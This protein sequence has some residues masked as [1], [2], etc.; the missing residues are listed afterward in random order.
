MSL[1]DVPQQ[2][3]LKGQS[4]NA[5]SSVHTSLSRIFNRRPQPQQQQQQLQRSQSQSQNQNQQQPESPM[6]ISPVS[7]QSQNEPWRKDSTTSSSSMSS[8]SSPTAIPGARF[9]HECGNCYPTA[10][11]KFCPECGEKRVFKA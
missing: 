2:P 7:L 8:S 10:I 4:Q 3:Q 5:L 1:G 11:A 9:C 6:Q